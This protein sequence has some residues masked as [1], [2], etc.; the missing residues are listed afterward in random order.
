MQHSTLHEIRVELTRIEGSLSTIHELQT[1]RDTH[2]LWDESADPMSLH[3]AHTIANTEAII[4]GLNSTLESFDEW[5]HDS[6]TPP[7]LPEFEIKPPPGTEFFQNALDIGRPET[8]DE[9]D[10]TRC[11]GGDVQH[12][13]PIEQF[14]FRPTAG[15]Q[16][17][18][19]Y[20]CQEC[21]TAAQAEY[22]IVK[23]M[24]IR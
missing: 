12:S 2:P 23:R 17:Q 8:N 5:K 11:Q 19:A 15:E 10:P 1:G 21:Y 18:L 13:G 24:N 3:V 4:R 22:G 7:E 9:P 6:E 16:W 20:W 14:A